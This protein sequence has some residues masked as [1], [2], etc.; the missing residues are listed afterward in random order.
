MML[1]FISIPE[2]LQSNLVV[3]YKLYTYLMKLKLLS[4]K[5]Y[6]KNLKTL[7]NYL[8]LFHNRNSDHILNK[9][10]PKSQ[11]IMHILL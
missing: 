11:L 2:I 6:I 7:Q 3:Y 8:F 5:K 9:I 4:N 1:D 10:D